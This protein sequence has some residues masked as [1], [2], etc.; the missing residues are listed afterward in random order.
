MKERIEAIIQKI[1]CSDAEA[2]RIREAFDTADAA[3]E[4]QLRS[5]GEPY[6]IHPLAVAEILA[7]LGLDPDTIIAGLL[8]DAIED[9]NTTYAQIKQKFGVSVADMVEGVTKLT[10]M[11]YESAEEEEIENLRKMFI[12]MARDIRVIVIKLVDRLHNMRTLMYRPPEKQRDKALETM[13]IYAPIAHRLGMNSIKVE[14]EDLAIKYLDPV[15]YKE[16]VDYLEKNNNEGKTMLDRSWRAWKERLAEHEI[17]AYVEG[18]VKAYLRDL[19][20]GLYD[21]PRYRADLRRLRHARHHTIPQCYNVL[22]IVHELYHPMPGRFK[23]YIHAEA[24]YVPEPSYDRH[25]PRRT[26]V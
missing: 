12:A 14:L 2:T 6:I 20:Q 17:K 24:Q 18:R 4:H 23:D 5:S 25:R 15:G 16:I 9:T 13:E 19:S 1:G 3:H 11:T 22:G 8:H 21:E 7:D 10:R 26:A